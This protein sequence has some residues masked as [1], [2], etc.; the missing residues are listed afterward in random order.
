MPVWVRA[1]ARGPEFFSGLTRAR[2]YALHSEGKV[3]SVSVGEPGKRG[4][5]LWDL[6]SILNYIEKC[7]ASAAGEWQR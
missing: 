4:C 7:G 2:L 3:R 1:P 6:G 5:R